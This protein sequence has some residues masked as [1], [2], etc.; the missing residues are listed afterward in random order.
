MRDVI[1]INRVDAT[2]F[3]IIR[4]LTDKVNRANLEEQLKQLEMQEE[5]L[6]DQL[7]AIENNK[8]NILKALAVEEGGTIEGEG[9]VVNLKEEK[10]KKAS[11][12]HKHKK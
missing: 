2:H 8:E 5:G 4:T 11:P 10:D 12:H 7:E 3:E 6:H 9:K 1:Q